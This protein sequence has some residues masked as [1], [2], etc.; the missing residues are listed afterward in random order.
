MIEDVIRKG[1]L[2]DTYGAL[3]TEK[4]RNCMELYFLSDWSLAEIASSLQI[5]RQAVH[6]NLHRASLALEEYEQALQLL[7]KREARASYVTKIRSLLEADA[8]TEREEIE[9][10]LRRIEEENGE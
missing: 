4:Q 5:S 3:L 8:A 9:R 6:D 7:K 2:L 1:A 10:L